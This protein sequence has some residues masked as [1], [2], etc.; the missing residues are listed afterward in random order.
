MPLMQR[1]F[2][3]LEV[4]TILSGVGLALACFIVM[5]HE[6]TLAHDWMAM[7]AGEIAWRSCVLLFIGWLLLQFWASGRQR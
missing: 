3:V 4:L 1:A 6:L 5:L 7:D 2:G